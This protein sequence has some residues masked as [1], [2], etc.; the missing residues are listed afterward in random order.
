MTKI[1]HSQLFTFRLLTFIIYL[2]I[3]YIDYK[4]ISIKFEYLS[5]LKRKNKF[6]ILLY[7]FN[8]V[9]EKTELK[10][11]FENNFIK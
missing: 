6:T 2:V 4:T 8:G 1:Q 7:I 10:I 5:L 3:F 11:N 9:K